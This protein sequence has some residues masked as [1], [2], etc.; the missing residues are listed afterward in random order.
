MKYYTIQACGGGALNGASYSDTF[1]LGESAPDM[2]WMGVQ[3]GLRTNLDTLD[4]RKIS[5]SSWELNP[6]SSVIWTTA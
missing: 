5:C 1:T 6:V 2:H 3:L 4:K